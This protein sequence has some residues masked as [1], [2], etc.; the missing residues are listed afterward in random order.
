MLDP[1]VKSMTT[2]GQCPV[3]TYWIH[4]FPGI[5][6]VRELWNAVAAGDVPFDGM[7]AGEALYAISELCAAIAETRR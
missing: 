4:D 3:D 6:A 1:P 2:V 5:D 7:T